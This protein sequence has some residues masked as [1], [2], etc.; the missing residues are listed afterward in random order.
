MIVKLF[1][2][3]P[4]G[5]KPS[6]LSGGFDPNYFTGQMSSTQFVYNREEIKAR[7]VHYAPTNTRAD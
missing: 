6:S 2:E 5:S 4:L 7:G 1:S 3:E